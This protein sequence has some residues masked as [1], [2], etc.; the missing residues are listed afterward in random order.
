M[1]ITRLIPLGVLML[2]LSSDSL[3]AQ[4]VQEIE[5]AE[6][7]VPWEQSRPRDPFVA[8][9]GKIWFVGQRSH[10]AA[11]LDRE[12]GEFKQFPLDDGTGPHNLIVADDGTVFYAGNLVRHIGKL[13]P[14]SGEIEKY[15][16][17]D[18]AARD[19]HTLVFGGND[20]VWFS[21]Q[22]GNFV[23][24]FV[25]ETG[26][27]RLVKAPEVMSGRGSSSRPYG[28][29][30]DSEH[31]PWIALF[32]TNKIATVDPET[33]ELTA[34][35]LPDERTRPRRLV[36]DSHDIIWYVDYSLGRL[37]RLDPSTGEVKEWD[38]PSGSDARPYAVEIDPSDRIWFVETGVQPNKF[39]GFDPA[40]EE[41][42]SI[43][44]VGSGGGTIRHMFYEEATNSIWFGADTNTIGQ[45]KL[46]PL[47]PRTATDG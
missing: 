18:E 43:T 34:F 28:I 38:N 22:G 17:P 33:M 36:I 8:P 21:V 35:D 45:A 25:P 13:D 11:W 47:R 39:V 4:M 44:E 26:D 14:Q 16:M 12:T 40:T 24:H 3:P 19:P 7:E 41:F 20:D 30:M 46:P 23:G 27:V 10:Y 9:D 29:K 37:G 15:W 31:H 1:W 5:I 32:N 2:G 6:W 42:F